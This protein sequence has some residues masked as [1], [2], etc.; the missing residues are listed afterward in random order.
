[1]TTTMRTLESFLFTLRVMLEMPPWE[2]RA[3]KL[4]A[5]AVLVGV[6][7]IVV[8]TVIE[9]DSEPSLRCLRCF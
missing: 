8:L 1:M 6:V 5:G 7:I 3:L 4:I 9:P 2:R